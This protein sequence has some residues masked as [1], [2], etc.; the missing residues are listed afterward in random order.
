MADFVK[1]EIPK[2]LAERQLSLLEAVRKKKGK[3]RIGVNEVTKAIERGQAKLVLIAQ[4]VSPAELVMHLPMLC[5][6]KNIAYTYVPTRKD[7]GGKVGIEVGTA[8]VAVTDEG[9]MKKE[10]QDI[11]KKLKELKK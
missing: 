2:E 1:F 5:E 6:E 10:L 7:L 11:E 3:I 4:D 8:A 9:E